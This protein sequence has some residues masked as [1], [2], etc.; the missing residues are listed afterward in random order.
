MGSD[1]SEADVETIRRNGTAIL[2]DL[3]ARA[4]QE[5]RAGAGIVF[6]GEAN[7]FSLKQDEA[8]TIARGAEVASRQGIYLGMALAVFDGTGERPLEN[9]IVMIDPRGRVAFEYH[10]GIPVP[11]PEAAMQVMGDG[12]IPTLESPY[13]RLGATICFDMDFPGYLRQAG[14]SHVDILLVPSNDWAAIDPWH[15]QMARLRAIEQGFNLVRHT[16]GG[17]SIACDHQG[18]VLGAMDH[19]T[20][21]TRDLV[22]HVPTRGVETIYARVG[23]LFAWLC[24]GGLVLL[25][26]IA[27]RG[28]SRP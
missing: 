27:W 23:D 17:L 9:K 6:W 20:T 19:Y 4:A 8:A 1:A 26:V 16:S 22:A 13:G 12:R 21:A 3:L 25:G 15:T 28:E 18:R 5:A 10:K 7:G 14:R 11:G 24:T 2:D